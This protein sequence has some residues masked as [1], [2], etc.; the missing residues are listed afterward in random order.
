MVVYQIWRFFNVLGTIVCILAKKIWA[1]YF[2]KI[3]FLVKTA[4]VA[5]WVNLD[6]M[7]FQAS[8]HTVV[9][10]RRGQSALCYNDQRSNPVEVGL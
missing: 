7:L 1:R 6:Y 5:I 3:T 8:G 10:L 4:V 9:Y 2:E